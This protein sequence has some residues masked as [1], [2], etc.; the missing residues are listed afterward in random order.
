MR[1]IRITRRVSGW[2]IDKI[3]GD[4][5][6]HIF[7]DGEIILFPKKVVRDNNSRL[8]KFQIKGGR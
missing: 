2:S 5:V 6:G 4:I 1:K 3:G 7:D 8:F